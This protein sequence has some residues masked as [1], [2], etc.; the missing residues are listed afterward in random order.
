[1]KEYISDQLEAFTGDDLIKAWLVID[2]LG[3][4]FGDC[5]VVSFGSPDPAVQA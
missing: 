1:M 3:D 2:I 5:F 4:I